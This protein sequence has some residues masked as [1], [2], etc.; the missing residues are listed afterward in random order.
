MVLSENNIDIDTYLHKEE[1][2]AEAEEEKSEQIKKEL[3]MALQDLKMK[4]SDTQSTAT[5]GD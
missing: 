1:N 5:T 2:D 4:I 3:K